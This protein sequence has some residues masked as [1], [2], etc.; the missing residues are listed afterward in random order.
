MIKIKSAKKHYID[1]I[2]LYFNRIGSPIIPHLLC[3]V[4]IIIIPF[5]EWSNYNLIIHCLY[6]FYNKNI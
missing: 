4:S 2:S 6:L 1:I 3:L 5:Y